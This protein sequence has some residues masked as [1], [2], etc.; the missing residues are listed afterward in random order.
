VNHN[1]LK[2]SFH[3]TQH[4]ARKD[5]KIKAPRFKDLNNDAW[6]IDTI[7]GRAPSQAATASPIKLAAITQTPCATMFCGAALELVE[8]GAEV[9]EVVVPEVLG[10]G[11]KVAD[12]VGRVRDDS[13]LL[14]IAVTLRLVELPAAVVAE[15]VAAGAELMAPEPDAP[16]EAQRLVWSWAAVARSDGLQLWVAHEV[17]EA[18]LVTQTHSMSVILQPAWETQFERQVGTCGPGPPEGTAEGAA[19]PSVSVGVEVVL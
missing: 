8:G 6:Q 13:I 12:G 18:M 19:P 3:V 16:P 4:E 2:S 11:V 15:P 9:N 14:G 17:M 10:L 7:F 1:L 5:K